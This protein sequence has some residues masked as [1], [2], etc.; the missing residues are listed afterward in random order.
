MQR[1]PP[2]VHHISVG[3]RSTASLH[4]FILALIILLGF[5][6]R[7]YRIDAV[8]LRGDEAFS[9]QYWAGQ[10]LSES[11]RTVATIEPH[12]LLTYVTF[13]GWGLVAGLGE[14][15]MRMLPALTN[16]LGIPALYA[17]G[18]K[19]GG[20]GMGMLAALLW[21]VHPYQI[22]Y[23]QDAR[24]YG[25]WAGVSAV[26]LWLGYRATQRDRTIDWA[27]YA[28]TAGIAANIFYDD[29]FTI[30]AFGL[31]VLIT[32]WGDWRLIRRAAVAIAF[33]GM[34]ALLSFAVFQGALLAGGGYGGTAGH[35]DPAKLPEFLTTL[36]FGTTLPDDVARVIWLPLVL[37]VAV[38]LFVLW[39]RNSKQAIFLGFSALIP[40]AIL[41]ILSLRLKIFA[42]HYILSTVPAYILMV[43][44]L[45]FAFEK[46][47]ND[48]EIGEGLRPSP[49]IRRVLGSAVV[50]AILMLN[51][52]S[53]YNYY[54]NPAKIKAPNWPAATAYI[55]QHIA[56]DDLVVQL[57]ID[58]AFGYYYRAPALDIALPSEPAQSE[59]AIVAALEEHTANRPAVWLV[60]QPYPDWPNRD[61]VENWMRANWQPVLDET[62]AGLRVQQF[63]PWTVRPDEIADTPL[64]TFGDV[65]E[66]AGARIL[67]PA[68]VGGNLIVWL[69]WR[70]IGE[71]NQPLKVFVHLEGAINPTT[72]SPLWSQDDQFPQDGRIGTE[73]WTPGTVYRDVYTL[74]TG[75]VPPAAYTLRVGLY[76]P[77]SGE[78]LLTAEGDRH[79]LGN[80]EL[81]NE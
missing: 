2:S 67:Y 6:L 20:R 74:P 16:L 62:I 71:S 53:L 66:L 72:G 73:S 78:R 23:A 52:V 80:I 59:D 68:E 81:S 50:G 4:Y 43:V 10:P 9:V 64:A 1:H 21:A 19:M 27:A 8:P 7:L 61:V 48:A 3:T 60:G 12:P 63:R 29:L 56:P 39:R 58:P 36:F 15:P 28:V 45:A 31:F 65:A 47:G 57:A 22:W 38:S 32:R 76:E 13:R 30:G 25:I 46:H 26:A 17:L 54:F 40:L 41:C 34:T 75:D 44:G 18:R 5:G 55:D 69:Y 70:A 14:L 42:P 11:L 79:T 77:E 24:N 37:L 49:T 35:F 51:A 33:P